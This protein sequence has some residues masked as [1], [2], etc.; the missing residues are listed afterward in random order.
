M[1]W[2]GEQH[3]FFE[4][5]PCSVAQTGVQWHNLG[6]LQ[7]PRLGFKQFS[8]LSLS[9]SSD[10]RCMPPHPA[11]FFIHFFFLRWDL[12]LSPRLECSGAISVQCNLCLLD[13]SDSPVLA[14]QVAGVT[15]TCHHSQLIFAFLVETGFLHVGQA[16]LELLTSGD[17]PTL[18]SQS[19]GIIGMSHR[20][21]PPDSVF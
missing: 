10:Y 18:A 20:T 15:G 16:D 14:S 12:A 2:S 17:L 3:P 11:N 9:S 4:M 7:P 13:S 6:S 21:W 1:R 8:C 19:A 5:G